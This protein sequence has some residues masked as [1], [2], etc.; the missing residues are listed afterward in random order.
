MWALK[1][2]YSR[3]DCWCSSPEVTVV[4][5]GKC[6]N[7]RAHMVLSVGNLVSSYAL[8]YS[9]SLQTFREFPSES[10]QYAEKKNTIEKLKV[11]FCFCFF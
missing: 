7:R 1:E 9:V 8:S 6:T 4:L 11:C 5:S 3:A 10:Y 2:G